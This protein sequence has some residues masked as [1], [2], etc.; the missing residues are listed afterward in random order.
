MHRFK[1]QLFFR[2]AFRLSTLGPV[3]LH[4]LGHR[5]ALRRR[6]AAPSPPSTR[7]RRRG[8]RARRPP[9]RATTAAC[10]NET[11]K[12]RADCRF[13]SPKLLEARLRPKSRQPLQFLSIQIRHKTSTV[14]FWPH[15]PTY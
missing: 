1:A 10:A 7:R 2:A 12:G 14:H 5:F 6:H 15:R 13:L 4:P 8:A 9:T 3:F 11:R